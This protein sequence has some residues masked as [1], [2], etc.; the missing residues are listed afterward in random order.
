MAASKPVCFG[1]DTK[2]GLLLLAG[3]NGGFDA[4]AGGAFKIVDIV[5]SADIVVEVSS[6]KVDGLGDN[7]NPK[8]SS[9]TDIESAG[10]TLSSNASVGASLTDCDTAFEVGAAVPVPAV[11]MDMLGLGFTENATDCDGV[12][13][14]ELGAIV[15]NRAVAKGV[16]T[17]VA[18]ALFLFEGGMLKE[19]VD[20]IYVGELDAV[21]VGVKVVGITVSFVVEVGNVGGRVINKLG[22]FDNMEGAND[23]S[24]NIVGDVLGAIVGSSELSISVSTRLVQ[25]TSVKTTLLASFSSSPTFDSSPLSSL[26]APVAAAPCSF[27]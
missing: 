13:A 2:V 8:L 26:L 24:S 7:V 10:P 15:V 12:G 14:T 3:M 16:G 19:A 17:I 18:P 27:K 6:S 20:G 9:T 4:G 1:V 5:G 21:V 23:V 25:Y 22:A 11:G